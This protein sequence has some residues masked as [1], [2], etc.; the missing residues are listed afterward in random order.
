MDALNKGNSRK[1][2]VAGMTRRRNQQPGN[3]AGLRRILFRYQFSDHLASVVQLPRGSAVVLA[4]SLTLG[5]E[6][7]RLGRLQNPRQFLVGPRLAYI[8]LRTRGMHLQNEILRGRD[9]Q[10]FRHFRSRKLQGNGG[11]KRDQQYQQDWFPHARDSSTPILSLSERKFGWGGR[12]RTFTV[13]INSEVSY[14]L[15]HAPA[16]FAGHPMAARHEVGSA[17]SGAAEGSSKIARRRCPP[18]PPAQVFQRSAGAID[19]ARARY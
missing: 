6:E 17:A 4:D 12:I 7:F 16:G 5:V 14:Q 15:D 11:Q 2:P 3:R 18:I 8:D 1:H 19:P 10:F 9:C 13:L